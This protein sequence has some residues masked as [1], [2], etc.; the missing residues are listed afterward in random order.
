MSSFEITGSRQ[1]HGEITPQGAKNEALQVICACL[2][3]R[4][5]VTIHNI[6]GI[7]DV[8]KLIELLTSLGVTVSRS[9]SSA[10]FK[11]GGINFDY[12]RTKEFREKVGS[13]RGSIMILGPMLS[14]YGK[15]FV[16]LPGGD[17]IGRRRLDTHFAGL[18]KLGAKFTYNPDEGWYSVEAHELKGTY[19]LLDE[20]SVT[21]TANIIMASVLAKGTTTIFNAACEPYIY[22]LCLMLERMGAKIRGIGSN[23]LFIDGVESLGGCKHTLLS[24]MIEVGSFIGMAAMTASEITIKN[25][26]YDELGIIPDSFRRLGIQLE[27]IGDDIYQYSAGRCHPGQGQRSHPPEDV[28][29]Q[30]VFC[31]QTHR[32]GSQDYSLRPP[33]CH[34]DRP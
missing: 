21:G 13:L 10:T 2:L 14:R 8:N 29:K 26:A 34:G 15:G 23:L 6:P 33:P 3:T 22:Q 30:A 4:E 9:G 16:Y 32:H 1:L 19:M 17:K 27:Q 20:A 11:A 24:D 25:V 12:L 31:G 18:G 5:E 7:R 28:R